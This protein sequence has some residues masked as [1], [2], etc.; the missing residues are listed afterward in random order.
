MGLNWIVFARRAVVTNQA[1]S[2]DGLSYGDAIDAWVTQLNEHKVK[3][4]EFYFYQLPESIRRR[5]DSGAFNETWESAINTITAWKDRF[6]SGCQI[7]SDLP[8]CRRGSA[9]PGGVD[10]NYYIPRVHFAPR[11]WKGPYRVV[12]EEINL[13]E[14][15]DWVQRSSVGENDLHHN[16]MGEVINSDASFFPGDVLEFPLFKFL[17][18][19]AGP[20]VSAS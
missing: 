6:L 13:D 7:G 10:N 14:S 20:C 9:A 5:E 17:F 8:Q 16:L 3:I 15:D 2:A 18:R 1:P 4:R 19:M 12:K 11:L